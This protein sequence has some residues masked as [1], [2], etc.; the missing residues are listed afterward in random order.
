MPAEPTRLAGSAPGVMRPSALRE[1]LRTRAGFCYAPPCTRS[2][3]GLGCEGDHVGASWPNP[4]EAD[5]ARAHLAVA[6]ST[7]ARAR[8]SGAVK[9]EPT[10]RSRGVTQSRRGPCASIILVHEGAVISTPPSE[11]ESSL[12]TKYMSGRLGVDPAMSAGDVIHCIIAAWMLVQVSLRDEHSSFGAAG[13]F[14]SPLLP[15]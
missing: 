8:M 2:L 11:L 15:G 14:A 12:T 7:D 13:S 5:T 1:C 9:P 10:T 4:P 3:A 6:F